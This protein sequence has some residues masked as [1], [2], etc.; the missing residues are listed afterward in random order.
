MA[1]LQAN[2]SK[3]ILTEILKGYASQNLAFKIGG[4]S[5]LGLVLLIYC[6]LKSGKPV[7]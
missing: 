7:R 4:K 2:C 1:Y 6:P 5:G 3:K